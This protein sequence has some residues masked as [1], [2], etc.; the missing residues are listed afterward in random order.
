MFERTKEKKE[1]IDGLL[2]IYNDYSILHSL[3]KDGE[4]EQVMK[5]TLRKLKQVSN[6][7]DK[8]NGTKNLE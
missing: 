6:R 7:T 3:F 5:Q 1:L 8:D 4:Y 2:D